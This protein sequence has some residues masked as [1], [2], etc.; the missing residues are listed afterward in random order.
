[1]C[2]VY[3][4]EIAN[5]PTKELHQHPDSDEF[6]IYVQ[7]W[8]SQIAVG[9]LFKVADYSNNLMSSSRISFSVIALYQRYPESNIQ[10]KYI[11]IAPPMPPVSDVFLWLYSPLI[12]IYIE[13]WPSSVAITDKNIT[14]ERENMKPNFWP[15]LIWHKC[16]NTFGNDHG[17]P[18]LA[19]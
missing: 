3:G 10:H 11:A 19:C 14:P 12:W 13:F 1:M 5:V 6:V 16:I 2:T 4:G 15:A 17:F 7:Y 18:W 9:I 8:Y